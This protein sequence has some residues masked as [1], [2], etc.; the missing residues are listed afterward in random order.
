MVRVYRIFR[1][2]GEDH[3]VTYEA[4]EVYLEPLADWVSGWTEKGDLSEKV[5]GE[6]AKVT[7]DEANNAVDIEDE[8]EITIYPFTSL[9]KIVITGV[10]R[11][12]EI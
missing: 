4:R 10:K 5:E 6:E 9:N 7:I 12:V 8:D 3:Q 11:E 2:D 1:R